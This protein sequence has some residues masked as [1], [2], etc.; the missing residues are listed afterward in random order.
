MA[1]LDALRSGAA[2]F[3][4]AIW[5]FELRNLLLVGER[6]KRIEPSAA[7][8]FL[9]QLEKLDIRI[10]NSF[11]DGSEILILARRYNL[12]FYD[13]SYLALAL[14]LRAPL[15]TLDKALI[16]AANREQILFD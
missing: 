15:A 13:A 9:D 1:A 5:W 12:T 8:D 10:M 3:A 7:E 14:E 2:A 4:P 11:A 6:R 16:V